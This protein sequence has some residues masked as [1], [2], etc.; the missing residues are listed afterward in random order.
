MISLDIDAPG[1]QFSVD[2]FTAPTYVVSSNVPRVRSSSSAGTSGTSRSLQIDLPSGC[3]DGDLLLLVVAARTPWFLITPSDWNYLDFLYR[4]SLRMRVMYKT[5]NSASAGI[6]NI[7]AFP[8][9]GMSAAIVAIENVDPS[10]PIIWHGSSS[11]YASAYNRDTHPT[12]LEPSNLYPNQLNVQILAAEGDPWYDGG[13]GL[14]AFTDVV[15]D[16]GGDGWSVENSVTVAVRSGPL[17][18]LTTTPRFLHL[19]SGDWVQVAVQVGA[20]P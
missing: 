6:V 2:G 20:A 3:K 12:P 13:L 11:G 10:Y 5:Y 9:A 1:H 15:Q 16:T 4:S 19:S 17:P 18:D 8:S 14:P 7:A